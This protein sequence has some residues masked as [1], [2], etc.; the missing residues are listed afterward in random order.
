MLFMGTEGHLDGNWDPQLNNG[1]RRVDWSKIGDPLGAPMQ[2]MVKDI[3]NRRW[4]HSALRSPF[5]SVVHTDYSSQAVAF[6]RYNLQG[7]VVLVVV[8]ASDNQWNSWNYGVNMGG[9]SGM[10]NE[11]F[12]SQSPDY[13]GIN[14]VG[15]YGA[16]LPVINNQISINLPS[17]S[18][19]V[20]SK[21]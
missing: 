3:N 1:D 5:G 17:W 9:E 19:L 18:V 4:Q 11:I 6:K 21:Q 13:G 7:D 16:Y 15:N 20:F 8:N 2:R 10:W 12:N 14:T